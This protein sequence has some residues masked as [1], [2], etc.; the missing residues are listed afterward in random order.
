MTKRWR[1]VR[2]L[3]LPLG[4]RGEET[5][6]LEQ[7][8]QCLL[9][10]PVSVWLGKQFDVLRLKGRSCDDLN[11]YVASVKEKIAALYAHSVDLHAPSTCPCC[12]EPLKA[13]S[14]LCDIHHVAYH[15]CHACGHVFVAHQP[16]ADL[17]NRV[18]AENDDY[19]VEYV[20]K[21]QIR[22]RLADIVAPKLNWVRAIYR[23]CYDRDIAQAIDVGAGGGHFVA[24]CREAGLVAEGY[25]I[26][27][28]AARFA[29]S[30][31]G[32][33]LRREDFLRAAGN[34]AGTD[35]VTFWGLLEYT[36]EPAQFIAAARRHLMPGRGMLVVEVPRADAMST[37]IQAQ[38]PG[39]V[40]RH[41]DP[42]S[43]LNIYSD[44]AIAT[45][46]HDHGFRPVAAWYFGMDFYELLTQLA[47]DLKDDSVMAKFAR[48]IAPMQAWLD[49][50]EFADDLVV[51]AVP[52]D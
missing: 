29:E 17:I 51:A 28:A 10:I 43:H 50:A 38:Y 49:A 52:V 9:S 33:K 4:G 23:T 19:A 30:A 40:W 22:Q 48:L 41:L 26:N 39:A 35:L 45:L 1:R 27:G 3:A 5:W 11:R 24:C 8:G 20:V 25:E 15:R 37:A 32:I 7:D 31:F 18:F 2:D 36:P 42:G 14:P 47:C 16:K 13:V 12:R 46:L 44:A 6:Q 21:D 34:P